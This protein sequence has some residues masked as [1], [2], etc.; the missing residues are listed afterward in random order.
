MTGVD[1]AA[2]GTTRILQ[3][4]VRSPSPQ[5][6]ARAATL[7][8]TTFREYRRDAGDRRARFARAD[9]R[10][11]HGGGEADRPTSSRTQIARAQADKASAGEIQ[12][13][14]TQRDAAATNFVLLQQKTEQARSMRRCATAACRS[15]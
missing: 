13:I 7:Y 2:V 10:G 14:R 9:P 6:A 1:V 4:T 15:W 12:S 3:I 11:T 8:A 5:V